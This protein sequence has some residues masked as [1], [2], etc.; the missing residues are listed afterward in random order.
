MG[1]AHVETNVEKSTP[2]GRGPGSLSH[3]HA[4]GVRRW[5]AR[6]SEPKP[7]T[8]IQIVGAGR[9]CVAYSKA[10]VGDAARVSGP[11]TLDLD[12]I[13]KLAEWGGG[14]IASV[15]PKLGTRIQTF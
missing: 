13:F 1:V 6:V 3:V 12:P 14:A 15:S 2:C 8:C 11:V 4:G 5:G 7:G 9:L 10:S